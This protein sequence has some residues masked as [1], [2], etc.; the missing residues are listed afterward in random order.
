VTN[1]HDIVFVERAGKEV[2][3][4]VSLEDWETAR[5]GRADKWAQAQAMLADLHERL[6]AEGA[7]ERLQDFDVVEAIHAGR[8]ERDEQLCSWMHRRE[9]GSADPER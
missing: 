4:V 7:V 5:A 3:V 8:E 9:S 6:R 1:R 2:A